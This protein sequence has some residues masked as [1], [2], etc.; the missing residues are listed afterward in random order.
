[1]KLTDMSCSQA[2]VLDRN[3][4]YELPHHKHHHISQVN[5]KVYMY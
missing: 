1:M 5:A 4:I 2:E 3:P